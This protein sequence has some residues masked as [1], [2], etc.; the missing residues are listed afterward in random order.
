MNYVKTIKNNILCRAVGRGLIAGGIIGLLGN[1]LLMV[2]RYH[3]GIFTSVMFS[4]IPCLIAAAL[5]AV[6]AL[7]KMSALTRRV[8][9]LEKVSGPMNNDTIRSLTSDTAM[10]DTWLAVRSGTKYRFWTKDMLSSLELQSN[11][12][13]AKQAVLV[14][15]DRNGREEKAIVTKSAA[16]DAKI[17]EWMYTDENVNDLTYGQM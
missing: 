3:G 12:P 7:P 8:A 2:I 4:L 10:G 14:I 16:L 6:L 15:K 11:N 1:L 5:S 17:A 13:K 9:S